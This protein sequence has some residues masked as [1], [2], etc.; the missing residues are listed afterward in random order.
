MERSLLL[1]YDRAFLGLAIVGGS[2]DPALALAAIHALARAR[3][4][5]AVRLALAIVDA[6]ALH[7]AGVFGVHD[8]GGDGGEQAG[9]GGC[10]H[11]SFDGHGVLLP[12]LRPRL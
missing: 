2:R 3:R 7:L 8:G 6:G 9:D 5:M 12:A 11:G 10:N 4:R 1:G